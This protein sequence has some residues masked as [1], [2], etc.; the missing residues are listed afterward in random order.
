MALKRASPRQKLQLIQSV[1]SLKDDLQEYWQSLPNETYCRDLDPANPLFR[2]NIHLQLT[3]HLVYIFI[4]RSHIL[5]GNAGDTAANEPAWAEAQKQL[6]ND[7]IRSAV[8]VIDLCQTLEDEMGLARTSYTEFSSC[9][10]A[11]LAVLAARISSQNSRLRTACDKGIKLLKKMSVGVFS[12]NSE[13]LA[14]E[15]LEM[16]VER[17]NEQSKRKQ[18]S[19]EGGSLA[20]SK[21]RDWATAGEY[22]S[23]TAAFGQQY[24]L[25]TGRPAEEYVGMTPLSDPFLISNPSVPPGAGFDLDSGCPEFSFGEFAAVPGLGDWLEF[26]LH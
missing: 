7:C 14:I 15:A 21:F 2:F 24:A 11:V 4:G 16:A 12:N 1:V 20:Y 18:P 25:A 17:L 8:A 6:V 19:S 13:K 10:A 23:E 3:F 26:G 9:C 5:K 22:V